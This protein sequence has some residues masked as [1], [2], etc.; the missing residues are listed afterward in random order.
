MTI[1]TMLAA[2]SVSTPVCLAALPVAAETPAT[3][4]S[5]PAAV[6]AIASKALEQPNIAGIGMARIEDGAVVWT[7]YWGEQ[8]D[9]VPV[10]ADTAFNTACS[11]EQK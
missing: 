4:R 6:E 8:S 7:G 1:K 10:T 11:D 3:Q 2:L 5:A 9:G